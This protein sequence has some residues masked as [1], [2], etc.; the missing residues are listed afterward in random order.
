M[1]NKPLFKENSEEYQGLLR[2]NTIGLL[3]IAFLAVKVFFALVIPQSRVSLASDLTTANIL[4]AVNQQRSLRNLI[5]LNTNN[6]LGNAAQSKA[7]DMQARHYFA[8]VDPDGHYIWDKI[9]ADGYTPYLALGE[10]LAIEFYDTDSLI[11]AWMNSPTHRENL[12][13]DGFKDQGMGLTFGNTALDQYHSAIA[14]TFG[15]LAPAP[16]PKTPAVPAKPAAAVTPKPVVKP[17][18][19][20]KAKPKTLGSEQTS[21]YLALQTISPTSTP[22][23]T[24]VSEIVPATLPEPILP[25]ADV[26]SNQNPNSNFTVPTQGATTSPTT[27]TPLPI[28]SPRQTA[29]ALIGQLNNTALSS[30]EIN[31]YLILFAGFFLLMLMLS[32]IKTHVQNKF[33]HLDKKVNNLMVL[34]ISLAVIAFMYWL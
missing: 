30:Y 9:V 14:N 2:A 8:H 29:D 13:N 28:L 5:T 3:L 10:N 18:V 16:K 4:N 6:L 20:K 22:T 12:L 23:S 7:D 21:D 33:S 32:D 34:L 31:R 1:A 19:V 11:S 24:P 15:T 26:A 17:P 25:R 27:T